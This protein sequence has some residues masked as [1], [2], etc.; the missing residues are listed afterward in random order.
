M[1][2]LAG[3]GGNFPTLFMRRAELVGRSGPRPFGDNQQTD[4]KAG[5]FGNEELGASHSPR[6][7]TWLGSGS[8]PQNIRFPPMQIGFC[9]SPHNAPH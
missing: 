2:P 9:R 4:Q 1:L 7:P 8:V 5:E 6:S 3:M